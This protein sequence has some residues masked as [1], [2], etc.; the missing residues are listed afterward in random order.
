[1]NNPSDEGMLRVRKSYEIVKPP[2]PATSFEEYANKA[3]QELAHLLDSGECDEQP[4]QLLLEKY[5]VLIPGTH[6]VIDAGHNGYFPGV[7]SQPR[8]T[9]LQSRIPDFAV[10]SW[11]S[12]TL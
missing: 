11:N 6:P 7:I 5:P 2:L 12:G 8:L 1:M 9:G 4:Y 10:I 3:V